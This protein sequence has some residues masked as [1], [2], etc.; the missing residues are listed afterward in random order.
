MEIKSGV[1]GYAHAGLLPVICEYEVWRRSNG[2]EQGVITAL[3]D[4]KHSAM[5]WHYEGRA[6]DLRTR[7]MKQEDVESM[8]TWLRSIFTKERGYDIV[9][10]PTH[11][12]VEFE[13]RWR[14]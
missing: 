11:L 12:H 6:A 4:G 13:G 14:V 1:Y 8:V 2:Y 5:S 7:D 10:E 9:L 3:M